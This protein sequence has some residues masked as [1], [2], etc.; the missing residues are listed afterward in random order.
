MDES[1]AYL[2][3]FLDAVRRTRARDLNVGVHLIPGLPGE[4]SADMRSTARELAELEIHSLKLHNLYA[5]KNTQ[6]AEFVQ[7]GEL[8]LPEFGEYVGWVVDFLEL[9]S[10]MVVID[11]LC[12][13]APPQFLVGPPWCAE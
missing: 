11:R 9:T 13:E 1:R 6:L 12:G 4:T 8:R 5:A 3:N 10:P 2:R 7:R